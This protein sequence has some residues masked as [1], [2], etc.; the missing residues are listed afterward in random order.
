MNRSEPLTTFL[1]ERYL[2]AADAQNLADSVGRLAMICAD[3]TDLPGEG[4][5]VRYLQSVYLPSED[6]CFCVFAA[7]SSAAVL[8]VNTAADFPLDRITAGVALL[9]SSSG[10]VS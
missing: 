4:P 3:L 1:V 8:A 6:A 5:A 2:P 9:A 7:T 10:D